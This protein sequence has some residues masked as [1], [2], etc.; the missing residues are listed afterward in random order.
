MLFN[1]NKT[2]FRNPLNDRR[3]LEENEEDEY[4]IENEQDDTKNYSKYYLPS[5]G[6]GL[7]NRQSNE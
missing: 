3:Y 7:L 1:K 2:M 4:E 5:S 6:F